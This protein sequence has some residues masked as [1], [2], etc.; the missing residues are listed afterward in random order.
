M[1][2][3]IKL[4]SPTKSRRKYKKKK[5]RKENPLQEKKL[6]CICMPFRESPNVFSLEQSN[7]YGVQNIWFG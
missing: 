6:A 3:I 4:P 1:Y 7:V 2:E 5:Q